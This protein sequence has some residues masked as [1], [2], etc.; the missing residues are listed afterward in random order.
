MS[1]WAHPRCTR[2]EPSSPLL[3]LGIAC[4]LVSAVTQAFAHALL[5]AGRDRLMVRALIG[6]TSGAMALPICAL[7]PLPSPDLAR[8]LALS[9]AV[10][11]IY[12]LALIRAYERAAFSIAYPIARGVAPVATAILGM[13]LLHETI[14]VPAMGGIVIVTAGL[15][16]IGHSGML[17]RRAVVAAM[18]PG[19]LTTA[20]TLIDARAVRLAP[21]PLSFVAWFFVGDALVMGSIGLAARRRRFLLLAREEG[22]RGLLAGVMSF[23]TYG[24]ALL[25][26]RW[27]AAGVTSA[28]R[29]TSVVFGTLI[30][31]LFLR[32]PMTRGRIAGAGLVAAGAA[33]IGISMAR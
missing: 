20:Y 22:A 17:S 29:E 10:H 33:L 6:L 24:A 23:V 16:L 5:R 3:T 4:A 30:A 8:W 32:E 9:V 18:L 27:L 21:D 12:Q 25:A 1:A 11:A 26:L 19:L 31:W 7:V 15:L 28:L 2:S 13:A 14:S